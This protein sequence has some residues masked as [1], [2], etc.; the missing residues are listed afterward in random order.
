MSLY[1]MLFGHNPFDES[2]L[3][4]VNINFDDIPR[5]RDVFL[6]EYKKHNQFVVTILTRTGG[7]N[8]EEYEDSNDLLAENPNYIRD[9]DC[10]WDCTFAKF[11][12][13]VPQDKLE[14]ASKI[15]N[16][17]DDLTMNKFNEWFIEFKKNN[18]NFSDLDINNR[19]DSIILQRFYKNYIYIR[20]QI[21]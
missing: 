18:P 16:A 10:S 5:Y 15:Y 14:N 21:K 19:N 3:E 6:K 13:N 17:I 9:H 2:I 7:G 4:L 20:Y 11:K 8:R 1:N 12:F